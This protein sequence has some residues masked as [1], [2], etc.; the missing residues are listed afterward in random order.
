MKFYCRNCE[1]FLFD[2]PI[3]DTQSDPFG[4][5]D[6]WYTET[7]YICP[8]C[9]LDEIEEMIACD[10]CGDE[11][12]LDGY[13]D[14]AKCIATDMHSHNKLYDEIDYKRAKEALNETED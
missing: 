9:R 5:G 7:T 3:Q 2:D 4:T 10:S 1:A 14:C 12:P 6:S 11:L 13:D 8:T